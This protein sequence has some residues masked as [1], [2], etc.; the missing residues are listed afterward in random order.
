MTNLKKSINHRLKLIEKLYNF[1][2]I[3]F[4]E[5]PKGY[6]QLLE[7][8]NVVRPY[9]MNTVMEIRNRIEHDDSPPPD[10][11]RCKELV[12]MVWYLLK[13]TDFL[14]TSL[15]DYFEFDIY[16]S[17]SNVTQYG[18][19][20]TLDHTNHENIELSGWF[21]QKVISMEERNV[22][23][24]ICIDSLRFGEMF[25]NTELHRDKLDTDLFIQGTINTKCFDYHRLICHLLTSES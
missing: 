4:P 15:T 2:K 24:C 1:K 3:V 14:V 17:N 9:L 18:G 25:N 19:A 10:Q 6:L 20:V 22:F 21:P 13:S 23:V 16:D 7:T 5:K 8:Y 11:K 12:D